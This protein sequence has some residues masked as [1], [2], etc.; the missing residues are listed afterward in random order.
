M[1]A[2]AAW[3]RAELSPTVMLDV[4]PYERDTH[5]GRTVFP[6]DRT[7]D[8]KADTPIAVDFTLVP[9]EIGVS[10]A[11]WDVTVGDYRFRSEA[12]TSVVG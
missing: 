10:N 3:F 7:L 11:I 8:V 4:G 2:L 1:N 9:L 6:I 12:S 5:W